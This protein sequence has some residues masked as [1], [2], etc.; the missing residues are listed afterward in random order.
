MSA[1]TRLLVLVIL[2][3]VASM[4]FVSV[5]HAQCPPQLQSCHGSCIPE[6]YL[7]ILEPFPGMPNYFTPAQTAGPLGAFFA[8]INTG[9]WQWAFRI[10]VAFAVFNGVGGGFDIVLSNGESGKIDAGKQKLIWSGIG[11]IILLLSGALLEFFNPTGF[12]SI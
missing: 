1:T 2:V 9:V 11:L 4:M 5:T 6:T 12:Q 10:A 8:Y 7:C 3:G